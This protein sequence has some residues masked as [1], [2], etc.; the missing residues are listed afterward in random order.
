MA[1]LV[2]AARLLV[3][4]AACLR[5]RGERFLSAAAYAKL[6][7]LRKAERVASEAVNLLGAN[8]FVHD[9]PVAKLGQI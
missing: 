4:D 6:F 2:R 9:Y 7:A 3:Y 1:T 8:G 5:E